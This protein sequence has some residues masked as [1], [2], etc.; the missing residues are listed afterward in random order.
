[1][2]IEFD[3]AQCGRHVRRQQARGMQ[4]RFCSRTCKSE[5]QRTQ[6]PVD[7]DWLYQK[8][9]VEGLDCT[10]IANL[11]HRNSKRV[12]EWLQDYS[13]PTRKRGTTGN[14]LHAIGKP[15][16]PMSAEAREKIRQ[17][18][19]RDGRVP[20]LL[21]DGTHAMKHKTGPL[22]PNWK[23]GFTPERA[24]VY[25][26]PEWKAAVRAVWNRDYAT[27]QKCGLHHSRAKWANIPFDIH[28]IIGFA[29]QELR[30]EV[31]NLVLLCEPCHYWV[32]SKDNVDKEFLEWSMR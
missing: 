2:Y 24:A 23:G 7:R 21:K 13:I 8:Y 26:S 25:S 27:C 15:R 28:H 6:K 32:H 19:L 18:R 20:Y 11:V 12:W 14:G 29:N 1:M 30:C 17:A 5:W 10:Q 31:S 22:H 16:R 3:C 9:I 4:H